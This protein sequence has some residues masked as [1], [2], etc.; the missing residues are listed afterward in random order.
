MS[1]ILFEYCLRDEFSWLSGKTVSFMFFTGFL[2]SFLFLLFFFF[3]WFSSFLLLFHSFVC[4]F[5]FCLASLLCSLHVIVEEQQQ[6]INSAS[7][8]FYAFSGQEH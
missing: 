2:S 3:F 5:V 7:F 8:I 4:L 1:N 6:T